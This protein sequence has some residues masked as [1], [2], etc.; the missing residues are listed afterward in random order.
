MCSHSL[1][2]SILR[3]NVV[4]NLRIDTEE[5]RRLGVDAH[6]CE[7]QLILRPFAELLV[8]EIIK[9]LRCQHGFNMKA[10][11]E[12]VRVT[13]HLVCIQSELH[14]RDVLPVC[15]PLVKDSQA[16][17][18]AVVA[19]RGTALSLS[20]PPK[21]PRFGHFWRLV[22]HSIDS[23]FYHSSGCGPPCLYLFGRFPRG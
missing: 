11:D 12:K 7:L 14:D 2:L 21:L 15:D 18:S 8:R 22:C 19:D 3:R 6:V 4:I 20:C 13:S 16:H 17:Y 5:T 9:R 10:S 1:V 23:N